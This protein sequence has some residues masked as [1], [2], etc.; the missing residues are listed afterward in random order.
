MQAVGMAM[1]VQF[2]ILFIGKIKKIQEWTSLGQNEGKKGKKSKYLVW[3]IFWSWTP[4]KKKQ[5]YESNTKN[6][7]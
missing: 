4:I 7:I 5:V 1:G 3:T 6:L 2:W